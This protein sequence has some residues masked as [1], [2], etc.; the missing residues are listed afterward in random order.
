MDSADKDRPIGMPCCFGEPAGALPPQGLPLWGN[1]SPPLS[2]AC[3]SDRPTSLVLRPPDRF[4]VL[5]KELFTFLRGEAL[6]DVLE[7]SVVLT[8]TS[9]DSAFPA[10]PHLLRKAPRPLIARDLSSSEGPTLMSALR[11]QGSQG[12]FPPSFIGTFSFLL[13]HQLSF[14]SDYDKRRSFVLTNTSPRIA[15]LLEGG[16]F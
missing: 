8:G 7:R 1:F 10:G 13:R 6:S 4:M 5:Y 15:R 2:G 11:P 16:P 3:R 12:V 14:L 9:G